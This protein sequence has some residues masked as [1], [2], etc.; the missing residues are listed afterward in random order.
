MYNSYLVGSIFFNNIWLL[1][2]LFYSKHLHGMRPRQK[3]ML[4][5]K[6]AIAIIIII[7]IIMIKYIVGNLILYEWWRIAGWILAIGLNEIGNTHCNNIVNLASNNRWNGTDVL[8]WFIQWNIGTLR[9]AN[10]QLWKRNKW[11][12]RKQKACC[13]LAR[14]D[15]DVGGCSIL[16]WIFISVVVSIA[17]PKNEWKGEKYKIKW[18]YYELCSNSFIPK[19]YVVSMQM[20]V[21]ERF[22]QFS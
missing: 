20:N 22:S 19:L 3:K 15:F 16:Y 14:L 21:K 18:W 11:K 7:K 17:L 1:L 6:I 12:K 10:I 13:G 2:L 5:V 8:L 4:I 9:T